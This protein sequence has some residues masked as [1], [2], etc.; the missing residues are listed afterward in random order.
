MESYPVGERRLVQLV[1]PPRQ[2]KILCCEAFDC[3]WFRYSVGMCA[4]ALSNVA[5]F[6]PRERIMVKIFTAALLAVGC[7][8]TALAQT[9]AAPPTTPY[10][11]PISLEMA[12][13]AVAAAE[14]EAAQHG[15]PM[16]IA[17]VD[18]SSNLVALHRMDNTQIGSIRLAEGKAHTA[19]EFRRPSRVMQDAVA[20]GGVGLW[21]LRVDGVIPLEGGVPIVVNGKIIG[22][23]GVSGG[24]SPQDAQAAQ[25]GADALKQ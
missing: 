25:A 4:R 1:Q 15:W 10:G 13:K 11:E 8:G 22:A 24:A 20:G 5:P 23:V 18:T 21:W 12:K 19:V 7:A 3:A 9:P 16:A 17:V 2:W 14:A 6:T